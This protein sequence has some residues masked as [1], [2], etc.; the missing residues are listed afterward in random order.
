[1]S[2]GEPRGRR[3][4]RD[5]I[6]VA[7][8]SKECPRYCPNCPTVQTGHTFRHLPRQGKFWTGKPIF[9]LRLDG[10]RAPRY[11][12]G[13]M[14]SEPDCWVGGC[15]INLLTMTTTKK[16][17][18]EKQEAS[19]AKRDRRHK[20]R[21]AKLQRLV[22]KHTAAQAMRI[23]LK[24]GSLAG[25]KQSV[26]DTAQELLKGRKMSSKHADEVRGY[27][28]TLVRLDP[29]MESEESEEMTIP[30]RDK[31]G[32]FE[33]WALALYCVCHET[34]GHDTRHRN[35]VISQLKK[36][37]L[38][39]DPLLLPHDRLG[40]EIYVRER[41][42]IN[43]PEFLELEQKEH[44]PQERKRLEASF[45][46]KE[47]KTENKMEGLLF[48][49]VEPAA[50]KGDT[51]LYYCPQCFKYYVS[52][53]KLDSHVASSQQSHQHFLN[54]LELYEDGGVEIPPGFQIYMLQPSQDRTIR[55]KQREYMNR[56]LDFAHR[57][58]FCKL[59]N[60]IGTEPGLPLAPPH[61]FVTQFYPTDAYLVLLYDKENDRFAGYYSRIEGV[62]NVIALFPGY[63]QRGLSAVLW[64]HAYHI[65]Q[66]E[67]QS[68]PSRP[69]LG[70]EKPFSPEGIRSWC[71]HK[72]NELRPWLKKQS[73]GSNI[74]QAVFM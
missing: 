42:I 20:A 2:T 16:N 60:R 36:H 38:L 32:Q 74:P 19:E 43:T 35:D 1:M 21:A 56:V 69:I 28:Q 48:Y 52:L 15:V 30:L 51:E 47:N 12:W 4:R 68:D 22:V 67:Q 33:P 45:I 61:F 57:V 37:F 49:G 27:L 23:R 72:F 10:K 63:K 5:C 41:M 58:V 18:K 46:A 26:K 55:T 66:V 53:E 3:I 29:V 8:P 7:V 14:E 24:E 11:F 25:F 6:S 17:D 64:Q 73:N 34:N 70:P 31:T 50:V 40:D 59:N 62:L 71:S 44:D 9:G 39:L 54:A 65:Y 13:W